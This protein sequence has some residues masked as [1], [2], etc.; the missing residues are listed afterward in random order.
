MRYS[1]TDPRDLFLSVIRNCL[2]A[3]VIGDRGH[4]EALLFRQEG[5]TRTDG[6]F[7]TRAIF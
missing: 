1:P 3:S 7:R 6:I 2:S 4:N 5:E